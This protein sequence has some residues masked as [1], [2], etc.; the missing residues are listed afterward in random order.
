MN[1]PALHESKLLEHDEWAKLSAC[2]GRRGMVCLVSLFSSAFRHCELSY[3]LT[4]L[5]LGSGIRCQIEKYRFRKRYFGRVQL[6]RLDSLFV[7]PLTPCKDALFRALPHPPP[8][9]HPRLT[10]PLQHAYSNLHGIDAGRACILSTYLASL[11][12]PALSSMLFKAVWEYRY[13]NMHAFRHW[14]NHIHDS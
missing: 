5:F 1:L 6:A 12:G 2:P 4:R 7:P 13:N 8:T 11:P 3:V 10:T 14:D 9:Q